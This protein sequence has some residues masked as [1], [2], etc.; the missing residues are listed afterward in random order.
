MRGGWLKIAFLAVC[1][2]SHADP[3]RFMCSQA[4]VVV[5]AM[6][7]IHLLVY[8]C[9]SCSNPC[10]FFTFFTSRVCIVFVQVYVLSILGCKFGG[11]WKSKNFLTEMNKTTHHVHNDQY[12][13]L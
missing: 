8:S 3:L 13:L 5:T 10:A 6:V 11:G 12:D 2:G 4:C 1:S 9:V 7:A